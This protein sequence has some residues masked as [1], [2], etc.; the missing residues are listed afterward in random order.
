MMR[1]LKR[2]TVNQGAAVV[3]GCGVLDKAVASLV[4]RRESPILRA[5]RAARRHSAENARLCRGHQNVVPA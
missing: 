4:E 5:N 1:G 2:E 3:A